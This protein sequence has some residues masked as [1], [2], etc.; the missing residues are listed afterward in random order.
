MQMGL[1]SCRKELNGLSQLVL[2]VICGLVF[3]AVSVATML[4]PPFPD[5]RV[6]MLGAFVSSFGIGMV[7]GATDLSIA[8]WQKGLLWGQLLSLPD[9]IITKAWAAMLGLGAIGG[10]IIGLIV[11]R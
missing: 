11:G 6:A 7:I 4:P 5:K 10:L 9:A 2:G 3:G 1:Q 8:G